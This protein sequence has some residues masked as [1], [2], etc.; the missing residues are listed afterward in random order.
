MPRLSAQEMP[1]ERI[2]R[3]RDD[4]HEHLIRGRLGLRDGF[5]LQRFGWSVAARDDGLHL[6][7]VR[8]RARAG[9]SH[10]AS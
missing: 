6:G 5:D 8:S 7:C 2:H 10:G 4:P 1:V 3:R 9:R